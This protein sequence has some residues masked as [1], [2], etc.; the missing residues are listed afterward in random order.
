MK[1]KKSNALAG[2]RSDYRRALASSVGRAVA[3]REVRE[4]MASIGLR[5]LLV[6]D[7]SEQRDLLAALAFALGIG[8]EVAATA[9]VEGRNREGLHQALA[10]VVRMA[11]SGCAWDAEWAAQLQ[12]ALDI[13]GDLMMANQRRAVEV[14][15]SARA[16]AADVQ[17][18]R[19][20]PDAIRQFEMP[21][22]LLSEEAPC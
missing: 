14:L 11:C 3:L 5:C 1:N 7:G 4:E 18:G 8:A 2:I 17:S 16:L 6:D 19:I 12:A 21:A 10:E 22:D 20:Q 15:D 9:V 13:S